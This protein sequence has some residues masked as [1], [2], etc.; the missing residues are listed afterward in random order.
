VCQREVIGGASM[1]GGNPKTTF[2]NVAAAIEDAL[3]KE[4]KA[5]SSSLQ[6]SMPVLCLCRCR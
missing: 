5:V 2:A 1:F 6:Y 3:S 4:E